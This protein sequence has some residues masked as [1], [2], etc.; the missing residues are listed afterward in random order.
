MVSYSKRL[1]PFE[2][3]RYDMAEIKSIDICQR[4]RRTSWNYARELKVH[5]VFASTVN[6]MSKDIFFSIV[7]DRHC[8][9]PMSCRVVSMAPFT[10]YGIKTGMYVMVSENCINIM[11]ASFEVQIHNVKERDLSILSMNGLDNLQDLGFKTDILKELIK[12]KGCRD[13]LST[14]VTGKYRNP[15]ADAVAKRLPELNKAVREH[16]E[17][18][19]ELAGRLAG[20]GIGLTPSSDD[21][22]VGYMSVYLADSRAKDNGHFEEALKLTRAMGEKAA[23]HTNIISGAFLKQCG[24]GLLSEDMAELIFALYSDSEEEAIRLCGQRIQTF[25][26]TSGTDMLTGVVL[27]M[28]NLNAE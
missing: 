22:L 20:G 9:Y 19:T 17:R 25:G 18:A 8:L 5:S 6:I 13:D 14:L 1:R 21:L 23:E 2:I 28:L 27:A 3:W 12:E 11:Q 16:D 24:M 4:L 7:S 10:E 15:C 26:S